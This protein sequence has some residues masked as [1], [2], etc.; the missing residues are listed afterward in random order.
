MS[1]VLVTIIDGR[2]NTATAL[3]MVILQSREQ[4]PRCHDHGSGHDQSSSSKTQEANA[5][6]CS[7]RLTVSCAGATAAHQTMVLGSIVNIAAMHSSQLRSLTAHLGVVQAIQ[8]R[9]VQSY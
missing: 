1:Q 7:L 2:H 5:L 3:A 4:C 8:E 6:H 9:S